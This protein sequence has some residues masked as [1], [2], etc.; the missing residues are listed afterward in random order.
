MVTDSSS[1]SVTTSIGSLMSNSAIEDVLS[2]H[3]LQYSN[4]PGLILISQLLTSENYASRS[5]AM[6]IALSVKN[7]HAPILYLEAEPNPGTHI[8]FI[9]YTFSNTIE[10]N[11]A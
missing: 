1:Q 7:Y 11:V 3:F 10:I 9:I 2:P 4:S 8:G 5:R 6:N